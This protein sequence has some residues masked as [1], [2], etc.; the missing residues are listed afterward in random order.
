VQLRGYLLLQGNLWLLGCILH[1]TGSLPGPSGGVQVI[2]R[3]RRHR[4]CV[5]GVTSDLSTRAAVMPPHLRA[6]ITRLPAATNCRKGAFL[7]LLGSR[8]LAATTGDW[9]PR[10]VSHRCSLEICRLC[11]AGVLLRLS[12]GMGVGSVQRACIGCHA[13]ISSTAYA[14]VPQLNAFDVLAGTWG[15]LSC[16]Y[17]LISGIACCFGLCAHTHTHTL[18]MAVG[19]QTL[20]CLAWQQL[21]WTMFFPTWKVLAFSVWPD[22]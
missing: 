17:G 9:L 15:L 4:Q 1:F 20:L 22:F 14:T 21:A 16:V 11:M 12:F 7:R 6:C 5:M 18:Q 10:M 13:G 3:L 19:G 8:S 2:G